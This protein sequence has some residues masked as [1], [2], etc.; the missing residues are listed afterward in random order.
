M[1]RSTEAFKRNSNE[2]QPADA[3]WSGSL[4]PSAV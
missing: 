1:P 4:V 2:T 3:A